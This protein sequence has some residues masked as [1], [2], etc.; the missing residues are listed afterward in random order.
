MSD[1]ALLS[2]ATATPPFR[3]DRANWLD[4]AARLAPEGVDRAVLARLAERSAIDARACAAFVDGEDAFYRA[5]ETPGTAARMELWARAAR[6][7][8][9]EAARAALARAAVEPSE[10]SL[11]VTASCTGFDAPG[12]DAH[13]IESLGL[14]RDC[15]RLNVGFMGCHAAVNAL[16]A[17]RDA[18]R[19]DPAVK[20]LVCCAEISSAHLHDSTRVDRLVANALFADGAAAAV[21]AAHEGAAM[22]LAGSHTVRI[23]GTRDE[24]RWTIGDHGFEMTLGAR[25]PEILEREVGP[26]VREALGR[27]RLRIDDV[28]AWAIHPGGPRVIDAVLASLGLPLD[29]GDA[30]REVLREHGNMSSATLLFILERMLT[31]RAP[32]PWVAL[33]FGPGLVGEML[34]VRRE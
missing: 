23:D 11:V 9:L 34:V 19:A 25:V 33:A 8:A 17:A 21:V 30:S 15:R 20:A 1:P 27:H 31:R 6:A 2:I 3:M 28:G 13:L 5:G 26:W 32:G 22:R 4:L 10:I 29:A 12:I 7:I 18:V 14:R 16:A 24:M